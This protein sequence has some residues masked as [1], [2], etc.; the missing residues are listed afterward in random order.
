MKL[1]RVP[2]RWT[3]SPAAAVRLQKRLADRVIEQPLPRPARLVAGGDIS[4]SPDGTELVAVWIVWDVHARAVV[5]QVFARRPVRFPYIP[6]LLSFREASAMIA[7]A[8]KLRSEPDAFLLD[9]QG[10]AHPRR[11]GLACHVGVLIDRVAVGCGKSLLCGRFDT[12]A[13]DAGA[14]KPLIDRGETIGRALRTQAATSPVFVSVGHRI[15]LSSA[16]RLVMSCCTTF[17]VPEPTRLAHHAVTAEAHR[18]WPRPAER[19]S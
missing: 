3:L 11:F 12:P 8:R 10:R 16:V 13:S 15:D 6:G 9:G 18:L 17:R 14:S 19:S 2:H 7:A 4:F 1:P 5:E